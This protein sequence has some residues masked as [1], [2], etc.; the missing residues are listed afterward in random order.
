MELSRYGVYSVTQKVEGV[1]LLLTF[2]QF[3][4]IVPKITS[5]SWRAAAAIYDHLDK[6]ER[7]A[8]L[9][10]IFELED[11]YTEFNSALEAWEALGIDDPIDDEAIAL[12]ALQS[13]EY[14]LPA[15]RGVVVI[16]N[17]QTESER[18]SKHI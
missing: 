9:L 7:N 1:G 13:N 11:M 14:I 15:G 10:D 5:F 6:A 2:E 8:I 3:I 12:D 4:E 16:A 18:Y 17:Y